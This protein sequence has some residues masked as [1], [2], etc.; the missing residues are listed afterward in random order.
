M[1][2][3]FSNVTKS[4]HNTKNLFKLGVTG[5]IRD[6]SELRLKNTCRL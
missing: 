5:K 1:T 3:Y 4:W 2:Q 6:A